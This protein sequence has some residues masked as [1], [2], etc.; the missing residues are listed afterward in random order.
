VNALRRAFK[1]GAVALLALGT[2]PAW[3]TTGS[4]TDALTEWTWPPV[5]VI[6]LLGTGTLYALGIWKMSRRGAALAIGRKSMLS[7]AAGWIS[8]VIALDSPMHELGEQLF[9]VHMTQH[10][11]LMLVCAPL[12]V[13]GRP[14]VPFLFALPESW[15]DAVAGVSR[16][17]VFRT[18]WSSLS[19]AMSAWTLSALGL[20][21]WHA[22]SLFDQTLHSEFMHA[23]QHTTFVVTALLFWWPLVNHT[24]ALG[25]GGGVAYVFTTALHTS[26]LGALLT[27]APHAWY[28]SYTSTAPAWHLTALQDQQLGGL[29]MW[30]PA[31]TLLSII[32]LV[33][34]FKW[35]NESQTRWEYTRAAEVVRLVNG[36]TR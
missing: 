21:I 36:G 25:Y 31:G 3:C 4:A 14:L 24:R 30:V 12:L 8:L 28:A 34:L 19:S 16:T 18:A 23:A 33:L 9:W 26:L 10:E 11:L 27:F 20:W 2:S 13:L 17:K 22:P 5:V 29:I 6:A 35:M 1:Y 32:T 7:F 15:R